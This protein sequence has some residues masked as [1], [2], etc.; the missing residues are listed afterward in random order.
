MC[1]SS[2]AITPL[3]AASEGA[4]VSIRGLQCRLYVAQ[5]GGSGRIGVLAEIGVHEGQYEGLTVLP[6]HLKDE[7]VQHVT[8][9]LILEERC[10]DHR[11]QM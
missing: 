3:P 7:G 9:E 5:G 4:Q 8:I 11:R 2:S 1:G 10:E 6:S